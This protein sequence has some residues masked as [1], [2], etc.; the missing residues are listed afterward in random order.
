MS[1][2]VKDGHFIVILALFYKSIIR[3]N[4]DVEFDDSTN[5]LSLH[6]KI[7]IRDIKI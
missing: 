1:N 6:V 2:S 3:R 7:H 5:F 4:N